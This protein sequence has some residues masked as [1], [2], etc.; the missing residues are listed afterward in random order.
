MTFI[1]IHTHHISNIENSIE[2]LNIIV[3]LEKLELGFI[4]YYSLGI[5]PWHIRDVHA[6][7]EILISNILDTKNVFVGECGLDKVCDTN[8]DLQLEVFE[9]QISISIEYNKPLI[10]HCVRA[11]N[12]VINLKNKFKPN[13]PWIIHGFNNNVHILDELLK[14]DFYISIGDSLLIQNSNAQKLLNRIPLNRLLLENDDKILDITSI[15][16]IASDILCIDIETL[17]VEILNNFN[18]IING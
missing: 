10:I 11:F 6:Q 16:A 7:M 8:F 4:Q 18:R 1:N 13:Q 5:H 2:V 15:F 9:K 14:H 12:E 17:K 3:G